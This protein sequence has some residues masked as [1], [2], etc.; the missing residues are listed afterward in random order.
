[1]EGVKGAMR[2]RLKDLMKALPYFPHPNVITLSSL[3]IA[4]LSLGEFVI[5]GKF[6]AYGFLLAFVV[7]ALDGAAAR[8]LGKTTKKGAFLDGVVDRLVEGMA[9]LV[10]GFM[11]YWMEAFLLF[12]FGSC[13][14]SFLKAYGEVKIG[15]KEFFTLFGREGRTLLIALFLFVKNPLI[16][17]AAVALAL[18]TDVVIFRKALQGKP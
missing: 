10:V 12:M 5:N 1:M 16:L 14:T 11:G 4:L 9:L 7:D 15:V 2:R 6:F 8:A 13:L 3:I 17:W 18:L